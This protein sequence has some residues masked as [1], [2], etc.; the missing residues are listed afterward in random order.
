MPVNAALALV[1]V[2]WSCGRRLNALDCPTG[3][4]HPE[5][6]HYT[7][8]HAARP[9]AFR[10]ADGHTVS[11]LE[12]RDKRSS[13]RPPVRKGVRAVSPIRPCWQVTRGSDAP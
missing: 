9:W 4:G 1:R 6:I 3:R 12:T 13:V 2:A 5:T 8:V 10:L 11:L 7:R